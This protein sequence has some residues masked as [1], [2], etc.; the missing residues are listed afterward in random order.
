MYRILRAKARALEPCSILCPIG[1]ISSLANYHVG[2]IFPFRQ[3]R[4]GPRWLVDVEKI[5][6]GRGDVGGASKQPYMISRTNF[7]ESRQR[8]CRSKSSGLR[9]SMNLVDFE[10]PSE[11]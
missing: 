9:P 11:A 6:E 5:V 3:Y 4:R 10:G 7:I 2:G 1:S 8:T